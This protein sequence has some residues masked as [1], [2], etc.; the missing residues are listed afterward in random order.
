MT[1]HYKQGIDRPLCNFV[2]GIALCVN[3]R[4]RR[5]KT[6]AYF[7]GQSAIVIG[8]Q[9]LSLLRPTEGVTNMVIKS[10]L[11]ALVS[12]SRYV[13]C[14]SC[15]TSVG[16]GCY[17]DSTLTADVFVQADEESSDV[18][19]VAIGGLS[20]DKR[21]VVIRRATRGSEILC[22][23]RWDRRYGEISRGDLR[24]GESSEFARLQ[25]HRKGPQETRESC[26]EQWT[27]LPIGYRSKMSCPRES[28][29]SWVNMHGTRSSLYS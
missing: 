10:H 14:N 9:S 4:T 24:R 26:H 29:Y 20:M 17:Y 15:L 1:R 19:T 27:L 18:D 2:R 16:T 8:V 25:G 21:R 13:P 12:W 5:C 6:G 7:Q 22:H 3:P 11:V 28:K 23:R